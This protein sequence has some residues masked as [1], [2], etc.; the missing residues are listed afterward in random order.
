M[1]VDDTGLV[2][3]VVVDPKLHGPSSLTVRMDDGRTHT[4]GPDQVGPDQLALG[5]ATTVH[6]SQGATFDTTHLYADGGGREL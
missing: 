1:A 5:Y 3:L 2:L 4:L 6:R